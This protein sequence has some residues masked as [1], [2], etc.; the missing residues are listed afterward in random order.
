MPNHVWVSAHPIRSGWRDFINVRA[1]FLPLPCRIKIYCFGLGHNTTLSA[2]TRT[3]LPTT[4]QH[5]ADRGTYD[6]LDYC[7]HDQAQEDAERNEEHPC[8]F[9]GDPVR[10]TCLSF[11]HLLVGHIGSGI[12]Q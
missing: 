6:Q 10:Q 3:T 2:A 4:S 7:K 1:A 11:T 8:R 12:S 5:V 9:S